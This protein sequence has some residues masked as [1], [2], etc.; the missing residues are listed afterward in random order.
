MPKTTVLDAEE[1]GRACCHRQQNSWGIL[2]NLIDCQLTMV[3]F[4]LLLLDSYSTGLVWVP[5]L[6]TVPLGVVP[7]PVPSLQSCSGSFSFL[8]LIRHPS[9]P[10]VSPVS[11]PFLQHISLSPVLPARVRFLFL[12]CPCSGVPPALAL[13]LASP[14]FLL[15]SGYGPFLN[16]FLQRHHKLP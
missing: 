12:L 15:P 8:P 14:A 2:I 11:P 3:P 16:I 5:S 1:E 10:G 13:S 7:S 4:I 9:S 6:A